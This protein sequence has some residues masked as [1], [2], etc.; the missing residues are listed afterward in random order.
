MLYSFGT[1]VHFLTLFSNV[2]STTYAAEGVHTNQTTFESA[3]AHDDISARL[4]IQHVF[5]YSLSR[6]RS[7][8]MKW[9]WLGSLDHILNYG[10]SIL[11]GSDWDVHQIWY[12]NFTY[13]LTY[14][15]TRWLNRCGRTCTSDSFR[16]DEAIAVYQADRLVHEEAHL[17][18]PQLV[19]PI[20]ESVDCTGI[21]DALW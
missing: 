14:Q 13:M 9:V 4:T 2:F 1:F 3:T 8:G 7:D 12:T 19:E 20:L 15:V 5:A 17:I 21:Y 11:L 16:A 18:P 6:V 10:P